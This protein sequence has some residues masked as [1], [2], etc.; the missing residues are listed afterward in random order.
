MTWTELDYRWAVVLWKGREILCRCPVPKLLLNAQE[1]SVIFNWVYHMNLRWVG[2]YARV[3]AVMVISSSN[4]GDQHDDQNDL[5]IH[6]ILSKSYEWCCFEHQTCEGWLSNLK[7]LDHRTS[8][9]YAY[10]SYSVSM[11]LPGTSNLF[12]RKNCSLLL[13]IY[14]LQII[15]EIFVLGYSKKVVRWKI[16]LPTSDLQNR[17]CKVQKWFVTYK[18]WA[19]IF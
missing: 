6:Q 14:K 11:T 2:T 1:R 8:E 18:S 9:K 10:L 12:R 13:M 19:K 3:C 4:H 17:Q 7:K 16:S 15:F 5:Q